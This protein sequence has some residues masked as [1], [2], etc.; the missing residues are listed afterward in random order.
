MFVKL[1]RV[2]NFQRLVVREL[3]KDLGTQTSPFT[4]DPKKEHT[5]QN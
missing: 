5:Y 1:F 2:E 4:T 3:T